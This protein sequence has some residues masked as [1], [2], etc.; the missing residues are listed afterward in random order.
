M[1]RQIATDAVNASLADQSIKLQEL[2]FFYNENK[3]LISSLS[4]QNQNALKNVVDTAMLA[5]KENKEQRQ[6]VAELMINNPE[7]AVKAGVN[8]GM[9]ME[10]ATNA[11]TPFSGKIAEESRIFKTT[12]ERLD[13]EKTRAEIEKINTETAGNISGLIKT[14]EGSSIKNAI[15]ELPVGQQEAAFSSMSAIIQGNKLLNLLKEKVK[16]GPI[17]GRAKMGITGP[18]GIPLLP[19]LRSVNMTTG[20]T[21]EFIAGTTAF[22]AQYIKAL[23]GVQVSDKERQFLMDALPDIKRQESVNKANIE[24]LLQNLKEKYSLQLGIDLESIPELQQEIKSTDNDN[25]YLKSINL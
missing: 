12:K 3:D 13:M 8:I 11:I 18:W 9:T 22:T 4:V 2:E 6:Q 24:T 5:Y 20:K 14:T 19:G 23:S 15:D 25:Q 21:N 17:V 10:Q 7:A 16:T 1:A